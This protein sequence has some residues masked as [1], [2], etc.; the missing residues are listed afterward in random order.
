V[1]LEGVSSPFGVLIVVTADVVVGRGSLVFQVG[2]ASPAVASATAVVRYCL[3]R[4]GIFFYYPTESTQAKSWFDL[5]P[6]FANGATAEAASGVANEPKFSVISG[7]LSLVALP[8]SPHAAFYEVGLQANEREVTLTAMQTSPFAKRE[9][10]AFEAL[11]VAFTEVRE[12]RSLSVKG[13]VTLSLLGQNIVLSPQLTAEQGLVF[14]PAQPP[15]FEVPQLGRIKIA[16]LSVGRHY[17][18]W[19]DLQALYAFEGEGSEAIGGG[20]LDSAGQP[21]AITLKEIGTVDR[22]GRSV[23]LG[24]GYLQSASEAGI[25]RLVAACKTSNA[26]TVSAWVKP[27]GALTNT[28]Q[29]PACIV[30]L[31]KDLGERNFT[32]GQDIDA[33][34]NSRYIARLRRI[35]EGPL[36]LPIVRWLLQAIW[37]FIGFLLS[38][39]ARFLPFDNPCNGTPPLVSEPISLPTDELSHVVFT[40]KSNGGRLYINGVDRTDE[41]A[42]AELVG[43]FSQWASDGFSL[44]LGNEVTGDRAWKGE[45]HRV[46]IFSRALSATEV[47][48]AYYPAIQLNATLIP[49]QLPT[50]LNGELAVTLS[51]TGQLKIVQ[52]ELSITPSLIL[53]EIDLTWASDAVAVLSG[54]VQAT[55]WDNP[56]TFEG[57]LTPE[58]LTLSLPDERQRSVALKENALPESA[59]G[60]TQ[61]TALGK[62]DLSKLVISAA[63]SAPSA[64]VIETDGAVT[65]AAFPQ[66][67][68]QPFSA[69]LFVDQD[70]LWLAIDPAEALTLSAG[71]TLSHAALRFVRDVGPSGWQVRPDQRVS[72][73]GVELSLFGKTLDLAAE[74]VGTAADKA[75]AD[76]ALS[77]SWTETTNQFSQRLIEDQLGH[78]NLLNLS[79]ETVPTEALVLWQVAIAGEIPIG[80]SPTD[81]QTSDTPQG[82]LLTFETVDGQIVVGSATNVKP[83]VP[84]TVQGTSL[85]KSLGEQ[86]FAGD[87]N[88]ADPQF[89]SLGRFNLFADWSALQVEVD[90]QLDIATGSGQMQC[91]APAAV[92]MADFELLTSVLTLQGGRL[93]LSGF[94]LGAPLTLTALHRA[95][96]TVWEG[97]TELEIPFS[98]TLGPIFDPASGIRLADSV[99]ICQETDCRRPMQVRA[100]IELSSAGFLARVNSRFTWQDANLIE[101]EIVLE[102]LALFSPPATRNELLGHIVKQIEARADELFGPTFKPTSGYFFAEVGGDAVMY[103]GDRTQ[104]FSAPVS[105][106]LPNLFNADA[107]V[108]EGIFSLVQ[109]ASSCELSLSPTSSLSGVKASYLAFLQKVDAASSVPGAV[110]LVKSRI[111]ERLPMSVEESLFYHY[112]MDAANRQIDLQAGM[113]L[114]VDYQNYQFVHPSDITANSGFVGSGTAYYMLTGKG[115]AQAPDAISFDA[116]FSQIQPSVKTEI[117]K[118]GAG[119]GLDTFQPGYQKPYV[120]LMYPAQ[121][122]SSHGSLV[123]EQAALLLGATSWDKLQGGTE[124]TTFFFRGRAAVVPEIAVVLQGRPLFVPVGTTLL[125]LMSQTV[126]LPSALPNQSV[127]QSV[128]RSRLSRVVHEGAMN[129]PAYEFINLEE[130]VPVFDLPLV[131]GDRIDL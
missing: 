101:E 53:N 16:Q 29:R 131:K 15:S 116:F 52:K 22:L 19:G 107:T 111:A 26:L 3:T 90:A 48:R 61:K 18:R 59:N 87:L 125:Q 124:V 103:L 65:F 82:G 66:P 20:A 99:Q 80:L 49:S 13:Q 57:Q 92:E 114:R 50:P 12:A 72:K 78:L 76:K 23:L 51:K 8:A 113:R 33:Q 128:G 11:N 96:R 91:Q 121:V 62:I 54:H 2:D 68:S 108:T 123:V 105:T 83:T 60:K 45:M 9:T 4:D 129:E 10:I 119:G 1:Y 14:S 46:A 42:S 47:E 88:S 89:F 84:S 130:D 44:L 35:S 112:G 37:S 93:T 94:W 104:S 40:R 86:M 122:A 127:L 110:A 74:L 31:S 32:L 100:E 34:G 17:D 95:E 58:A 63:R 118:V 38:F 97:T 120:R 85:L 41:Q 115:S 39:I 27:G 6:M 98:L 43:D 5:L 25:A 73:S 56:L 55:L 30:S 81:A 79:L 75:L 28:S 7:H 71:L 102:D 109:T 70:Q 24:R 69:E 126:S 36:G 64:W 67:L 106:T 77:L 117:A 21:S